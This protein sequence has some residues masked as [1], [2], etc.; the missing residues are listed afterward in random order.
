MNRPLRFPIA[1]LAAATGLAL[2]LGLG[3]GAANAAPTKNSA[4]AAAKPAAKGKPKSVAKP[5]ATPAATKTSRA[6]TRVPL[7]RTRPAAASTNTAALVPGVPYSDLRPSPQVAPPAPVAAPAPEMPAPKAASPISS[8]DLA[9]MKQAMALVSRGKID[10]AGSMTRSISERAAAKLVE[11]AILRSSYNDGISFERYVAFIDENPSWPSLELFRRRAEGALWEDKRE[12]RTVRN[13]FAS[14]APVS[15]K[16]RLALA[17]ALLA[18]GDR[19]SAEPLVRHV[20]RHESLTPPLE[21]LVTNAFGDMLTAADHKIRMDERLYDED[22]EAGM[23]MAQRL[24]PTQLAI[25]K[26]RIA[27][28]KKA[29]NVKA[30]LEAVPA[31]G[32]RDPVYLFTLAQY[33]RRADQIAEAGKAMLSVPRDPAVLGD[34]DQWWMERRYLA[35]KLLDIG[36]PKSAYLVARD[37][38]PPPKENYRVDHQFTAGWIA[39]RFLNDPATALTHF[40]RIP[41]NLT[42]SNPHALARANYWL[43]RTMEAQG[44]REEARKYYDAAGRHSTVYYGQLARAKLGLPDLPLRPPPRRTGAQPDVVRAAEILYALDERDLANIMLAD[45]GEHSDDLNVLAGLGEAANRANDARG[46][47]LLGKAALGR[48]HP[49]EYYAH[50]T[51]GLPGYTPIGPAIDSSVAYS[52]ARTESHFNQRVVSTAKA[53]GLMQVTPDAGKYIAKKFKAI[54]DWG[55]MQKDPVYNTQMGAAELGDLFQFYRGSYIMTF[56]GYNAGRGR[57]KDWIER[58]GDPRDPKVDP[59]DWVERI[60]FAETRN[61]VPRILEALQVYRIRFGGNSKLQIE[62]DLQRG[63]TRTQ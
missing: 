46:M 32:R 12:A 40:S 14:R 31:E 50:P 3:T 20:W 11:W 19:K 15:A 4:K 49:F 47:L 39:L 42:A 30:M 17:R 57:V 60:P 9:T 48:G 59:V 52:I 1:H 61:Y 36:D 45:I 5:V 55:R 28:V 43:G 8:A 16:G 2:L 38:S 33:L 54:F 18:Q 62:A 63:S 24:G 23:R 26:A 22:V 35:R 37:A 44:R 58:F 51:V 27:M 6:N 10:E 25:A 21:T 13:Y 34:L 7:P 41:E 56:A 53:V 29:G